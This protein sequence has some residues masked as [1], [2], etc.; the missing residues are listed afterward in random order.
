LQGSDG[1]I[2]DF[3]ACPR[4]AAAAAKASL[5]ARTR[6]IE[7]LKSIIIA[8]NFEISRTGSNN[9]ANHK[10]NGGLTS[11]IPNSNVKSEN[12]PKHC[13]TNTSTNGSGKKYPKLKYVAAS[14]QYWS[15]F[16][17]EFKV[18]FNVIIAARI[19]GVHNGNG[20]VLKEIKKMTKELIGL[21][22]EIRFLIF[23]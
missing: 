20:D 2:V 3:T 19:W 10:P 16:H 8:T 7:N 11:R 23:P 13:S 5:I 21:I 1:I 6:T 4:N 14:A 9:E 15:S 17:S 22:F 12:D 18:E